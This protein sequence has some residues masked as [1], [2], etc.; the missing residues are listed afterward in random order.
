MAV[1]CCQPAD[2]AFDLGA[3]G[4]A[5]GGQRQRDGDDQDR[6][7]G[8]Q[9]IARQVSEGRQRH[10]EVA[11]Q[12]H[13]G[14]GRRRRRCSRWRGCGF[15]SR[16]PRPESPDRCPDEGS[17]CACRGCGSDQIVGGDQQGDTH[18]VEAHEQSP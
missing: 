16:S 17:R 1:V 9:G 11:G 6:H 13:A 7:R 3:A 10:L 2:K 5:D 12:P 14:R 18:L 8:R 4:A 15:S